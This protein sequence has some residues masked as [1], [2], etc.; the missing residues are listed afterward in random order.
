MHLC[1]LSVTRESG[2]SGP[3]EAWQTTGVVFDRGDGGL[4]YCDTARLC[5]TPLVRRLGLPVIRFHDL[6]HTA[7]T[8]MLAEG[9][10]PKIVAERLGYS[11]VSMTLDRYSHVSMDMQCEAAQAVARALAL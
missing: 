8:V 9:V 3:D 2:A 11:K 5:F 7:A 1:D 4:P 10:H 6:R